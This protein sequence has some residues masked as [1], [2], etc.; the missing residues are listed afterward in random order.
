[1]R[2]RLRAGIAAVV[3]G[4][5]AL[6]LH[7]LLWPVDAWTETWIALNE[8]APA[9]VA[10]AAAIILTV[11]ATIA[12]IV[13]LMF[14]G[15][16]KLAIGTAA[17]VVAWWFKVSVMPYRDLQIR[18][19][20]PPEVAILHVVKQGLQV[21][22]LHV[23]AS[24]NG[25]FWKARTDR[26]LF[27]YRFTTRYR[28][29]SLLP[30]EL[31]ERVRELAHRGGEGTAAPEPLRAWNAEG[32]YVRISGKWTAPPPDVGDLFDG[33]SGAPS[34]MPWIEGEYVSAD[35]CLGFCYGPAA[36]MGVR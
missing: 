12:T 17:V 3:L 21:R 36:A 33:I 25:R 15:R 13:L 8:I 35:I 31:R 24:R 9:I 2:R 7:S 20:I 6:F 19:G 1:M 14:P 23:S 29:G 16:A 22:E 5:F 4:G 28:V 10:H 27:Q 18:D 26:R 34:G 11:A 30:R 32:W